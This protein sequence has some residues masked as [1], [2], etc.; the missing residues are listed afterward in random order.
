M[1]QT[2]MNMLSAATKET[3]KRLENTCLKSKLVLNKVMC[4]SDPLESQDPSRGAGGQNDIHNDT[5]TWFVS[6]HPHSLMSLQ[7]NFPEVI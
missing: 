2:T 6:F 1:I 4:S 7:W 3:K 5:E